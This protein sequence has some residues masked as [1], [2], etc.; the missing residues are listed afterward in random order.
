M[1]E[2]PG[3]G[4]MEEVVPDVGGGEL[5]NEVDERVVGPVTLV[6]DRKGVRRLES[7]SEAPRRTDPDGDA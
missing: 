5:A 7:G 2:E 6:P 3:K 4:G 1:E